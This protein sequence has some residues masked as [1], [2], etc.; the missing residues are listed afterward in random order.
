[1]NQARPTTLLLR[2]PAS[3]HISTFLHDRRQNSL[4]LAILDSF[5]GL[6]TLLN[7][8]VDGQYQGAHV[9]GFD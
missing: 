2:S 4:I 3:V 9:Y 1:M 7:M 8:L 5:A 6:A